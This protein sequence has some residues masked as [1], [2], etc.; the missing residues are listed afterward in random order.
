MFTA[1][2]RSVTKPK[3]KASPKPKEAPSAP[4]DV[5][6]RTFTSL[7]EL[8][9][10]KV[11]VEQLR[12]HRV[13]MPLFPTR[14]ADPEQE[15]DIAEPWAS[16]CSSVESTWDLIEAL[17]PHAQCDRTLRRAY[18]AA[19]EVLIRHIKAEIPT[20]ATWRQASR[21][22]RKIPNGLTDEERVHFKLV[23]Q[24]ILRRALDVVTDIDDLG[25]M[26]TYTIPESKL[27]HMTLNRI[28]ALYFQK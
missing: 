19:R 8:L 23:R 2:E 26:L 28:V 25:K 24:R 11:T 13:V 16:L 20:M 21:L 10:K 3:A 6:E 4:P 18:G 9:G 17:G 7:Q 5:Q 27:W 14:A 1:R 15:V 12:D 22:I